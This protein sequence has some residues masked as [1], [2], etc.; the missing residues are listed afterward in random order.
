MIAIIKKE[1]ESLTMGVNVIMLVLLA[2]IG[3][4]V[5]T[6]GVLFYKNQN[7]LNLNFKH[8]QLNLLNSLNLIAKNLIHMQNSNKESLIYC[9]I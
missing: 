4:L 9:L 7:F 5:T 2:Y 8:W 3:S 1:L 6:F